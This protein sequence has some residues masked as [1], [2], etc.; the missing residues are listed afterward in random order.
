M[1][2]NGWVFIISTATGLAGGYNLNYFLDKKNNEFQKPIYEKSFYDLR[3]DIATLGS[4]QRAITYEIE[5][6]VSEL[7]KKHR[8]TLKFQEEIRQY[9]NE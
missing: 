3:D 5:M 2:N 4:Q 1:L 6:T 8:E 9:L 7:E